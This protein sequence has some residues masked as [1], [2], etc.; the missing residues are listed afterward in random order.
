MSW[1]QRLSR[2]TSSPNDLQKSLCGSHTNYIDLSIVDGISEWPVSFPHR[3]LGDRLD[4]RP[5]GIV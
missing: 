4:A 2:G 1:E 5:H 3:T